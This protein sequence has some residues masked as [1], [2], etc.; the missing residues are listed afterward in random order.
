MCSFKSRVK[1]DKKLSF[2]S[3]KGLF[4]TSANRILT[5]PSTEVWVMYRINW[6]ELSSRFIL[7]W[8]IAKT[9]TNVF[10]HVY[11]SPEG[12]KKGYSA[13]SCSLNNVPCQDRDSP[14]YDKMRNSSRLGFL[15]LATQA[16]RHV[17]HR[18]RLRIH[19]D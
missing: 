10:A 7:L 4:E 6:I 16:R 18:G 9:F 17:R 3:R 19:G 1:I 13:V 11:S 5:I 15:P 2:F 14:T 8:R 12:Y